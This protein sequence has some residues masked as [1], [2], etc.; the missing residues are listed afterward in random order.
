MHYKSVREKRD[1]NKREERDEQGQKLSIR[2]Y[3]KVIMWSK[4]IIYFF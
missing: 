4:D 1:N 3:V 2:T